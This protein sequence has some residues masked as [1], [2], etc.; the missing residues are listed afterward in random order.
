MAKNNS[1]SPAG[2]KT[3][4]EGFEK[5]SGSPAND[6]GGRYYKIHKGERVTLFDLAI[7][8]GKNL[9]GVAKYKPELA[10][11]KVARP[12]KGHRH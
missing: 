3:V 9:P 2:Y 5:L 7:K 1:P 6:R 12:M 8:K 10:L 11:D 4:I